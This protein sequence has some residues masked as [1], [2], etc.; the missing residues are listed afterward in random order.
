MKQM[1]LTTK[2]RQSAEESA[3]ALLA[4]CEWEKTPEEHDY[5][6]EVH[7]KL[8]NIAKHGTNDG[9]PWVEP[10]LTDEDA[11]QR[12]PVMVYDAG[13]EHWFGPRQLAAVAVS[14]SGTWFYVFD[15]LRSVVVKQNTVRRATSDEIA[16]ACLK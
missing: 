1:K 13:Q 7:S 9:K 2:E 4:I 8:F 15:E 5:W 16:R 12:I 11:K 14:N 10:E 6:D 3:K